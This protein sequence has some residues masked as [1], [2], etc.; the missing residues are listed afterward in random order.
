[1][2]HASAPYVV[3][4]TPY[5]HLVAGG[6]ASMVKT[7]ATTMSKADQVEI[8]VTG[9]SDGCPNKTNDTELAS[10]LQLRLPFGG[11]SFVKSVIGW[12]VHFIPTLRKLWGRSRSGN[13]IY[14]L[15]FI[16]P[17]YHYFRILKIFL[18]LRF[19]VTLHGSD[20]MRYHERSWLARALVRFTLRGACRV[21]AV[22]NALRESA[23]QRFPFLR[24]KLTVVHNGVDITKIKSVIAKRSSDPTAFHQKPYFVTAGGLLPV[25]GY[26]IAIRAWR[27]LRDRGIDVDLLMLGDGVLSH[28]HEA[29]I[30][31]LGLKGHVHLLGTQSAHVVWQLMSRSTGVVVPSRQEGLPFVV[32]E[33]GV[34]GVP[35]IASSVGGIP[36][37]IRNGIDGILVPSEN[38]EALST[39]V[40]QIVTNP[41]FASNLA[42]SLHER[43]IA[44]FS[45]QTMADRYRNLYRAC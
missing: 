41:D 16:A 32:I 31:E 35:V 39:A 15:H 27:L 22:S 26:D 17:E 20:V 18:G 10:N 11:D 3:H 9:E 8:I 6:L 2:R 28:Q 42:E 44:D 23:I 14:H 13:A 40:I 4:V 33:A 12:A 38:S 36:E 37:V 5:L 45:A 7:L 19:I 24:N 34:A 30:N 1:M 43:V 21:V 29:L 25:K